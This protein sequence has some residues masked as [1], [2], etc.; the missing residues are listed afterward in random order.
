M[1]CDTDPPKIRPVNQDNF[2]VFQ[3]FIDIIRTYNTPIMDTI[4]G[5]IMTLP[6]INILLVEYSDDDALRFQ[7]MLQN[8]KRFRFTLDRVSSLEAAM[9]CIPNPARAGT[10]PTDSANLQ[11]PAACTK[12][13][14][15]AGNPSP[16][17][18]S[19]RLKS[20]Y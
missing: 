6:M 19:S 14:V 4:R 1:A 7:D 5:L 18:G 15:P 10:S 12:Q 9:D 3:Y 11:A 8:V 17:P 13:P 20:R 2:N 16:A